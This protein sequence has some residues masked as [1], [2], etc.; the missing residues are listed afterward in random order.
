MPPNRQDPDRQ[1]YVARLAVYEQWASI[2]LIPEETPETERIPVAFERLEAGRQ[3]LQQNPAQCE[4]FALLLRDSA[5]NIAALLQEQYPELSLLG[6]DALQDALL[7]RPVRA[8]L[9]ERIAPAVVASLWPEAGDSTPQEDAPEE[10]ADPPEEPILFP[11]PDPLNPLSHPKGLVAAWRQAL[12]RKGK[13]SHLVNSLVHLHLHSISSVVASVLQ[14]AWRPAPL[15]ESLISDTPITLRIFSTGPTYL[16][17]MNNL[18]Y[19]AVREVLAFGKFAASEDSPWPTAALKKG[20]TTGQAQ[21]FPPEMELQPYREPGE[22]KHFIDLM[23]RQVSELSDL[24]ADVLDMLGAIWLEQARSPNDYAR[25]D[26]KRLLAMRGLKPKTGEGGRSSGYRPDQKQALFRAIQHISNVFLLIQDAELPRGDNQRQR[27]RRE[28]RS[29]A[30]VVTD[31]AGNQTSAGGSLD[32]DEFLIRPGVLFGHFLFGPGRQMALLSSKAI[33]YDRIRQDWEKRLARY[34]SWQW[35]NDALNQRAQRTFLVRTLLE[36]C[37][38]QVDSAHPKRTRQRLE[39][40]LRQLQ[41]DEVIAAWRWENQERA[42]FR[43]PSN[44]QDYWLDWGVS[45]EAPGFVR[46]QYQYILAPNSTPAAQPPAPNP[47]TRVLNVQSFGDQLYQYRLRQKYSQVRMAELLGIT[48]SYYSH[49]ERGSR[50]ANEDMQKRI[51]ALLEA[52]L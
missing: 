4:R 31:I 22:Q 29:R 24:D 36:N 13:H 3:W 14:L 43:E 30:F 27:E 25:V 51:R 39:K 42:N 12:R 49:L 6:I 20:N 26:V 28:V 32:I 44:W 2:V 48:Q 18:P 8:H 1:Y 17:V 47:K 52:P 50:D 7:R 15:S 38:K 16:Y 35:R 34:L 11:A 40:A 33:Q 37:G 5:H 23:W 21:L 10:E 45:I 19:H 41:T 9:T 46:K